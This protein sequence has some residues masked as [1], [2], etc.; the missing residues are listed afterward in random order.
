M[1]QVSIPRCLRPSDFDVSVCELHHFCDGSSVGYGACSYIRLLSDSGL[2]V[3]SLIF[4][5][6]RVAPVKPITIPRLELASAVLAVKIAVMLEKE[7]KYSSISH[8]FYSD[9][10]VVLGYI[11]NSSKRFHVFVANRPWHRRLWARPRICRYQDR[12]SRHR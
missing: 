12:S 3:V 7:L 11:S 2:P 4:A 8:H 6:S 9:S 1:E 10:Q 5:K